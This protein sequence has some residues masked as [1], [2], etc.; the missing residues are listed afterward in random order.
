[1]YY[2]V[3]TAISQILCRIPTTNQLLQTCRYNSARLRSNNQYRDENVFIYQL[4]Y[5]Y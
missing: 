1:M 4:F 3:I 5:L 2:C